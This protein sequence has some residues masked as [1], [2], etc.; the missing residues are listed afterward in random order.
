MTSH[1]P[2]QMAM[3]TSD[4]A[5]PTRWLCPTCRGNRTQMRRRYPDELV[6]GESAFIVCPCRT[7]HG[8]GDLDFDPEDTT[9]IPY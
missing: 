6:D 3:L 8:E 2:E 5:A 4:G 1:E 9:T 7:C